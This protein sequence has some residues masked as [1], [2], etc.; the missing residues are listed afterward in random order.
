[1]EE[2]TLR[3]ITNDISDGYVPINFNV[4][5]DMCCVRDIQNLGFSRHSIFAM[6]HQEDFP[7]IIIGKSYYVIKEDFIDWLKRRA[8][9]SHTIK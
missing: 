8:V 3:D 6:F 9:T 1:M 7:K 2:N 5:P 4:L